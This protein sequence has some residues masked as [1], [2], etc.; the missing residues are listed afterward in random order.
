[1]IANFMLIMGKLCFFSIDTHQAQKKNFSIFLDKFY[2]IVA[3]L[4]TGNW[5]PCSAEGSK[6][7][8]DYFT[9]SHLWENYVFFSIDTQKAH[10]IFFE[11]FHKIFSKKTF[12]KETSNK[13]QLTKL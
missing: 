4:R 5:S 2:K 11:K 8:C 6:N 1:M 13:I 12:T 7:S 10:N 9:M 3:L